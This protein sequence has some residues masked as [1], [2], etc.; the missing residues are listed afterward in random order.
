MKN[1]IFSSDNPKAIKARDYGWMNAIHY[2]APARL[3]GVG[4][5]CGHASQ[6]CID[7]C[8]GQHSGAATYYPSVIQSRITKARRF[9]KDRHAYLKDM[10]RAIQAEIRK[11]RRHDVKLCVRPNGSTDIAFEGIR[12]KDGV[13]L[14][15]RFPDVQFTD[16]TKSVKRA[17]AH[18]TG[19]MPSNYSLTF[20]RSETNEADC[21]RVLQAGGNVA[22]VFRHKPATWH[23][24]TVIDGDEHD[25]RHLDPRG[26]V[27]AL[28][29]KGLKA[30]RDT[31][32]FVL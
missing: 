5:L 18:A 7:L 11:A 13:T 22:V 12:D 21:I 27:V 10:T 6:G 28:S 1:R 23:G 26:V 32:G 2:M 25:L 14:L 4:N 16:Y 31:S 19:K 8:L 9:M 24:F 3:A 15:E 30:R 20:S 29:P 17:L